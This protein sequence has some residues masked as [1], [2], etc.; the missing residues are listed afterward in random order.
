MD[1]PQWEKRKE[2]RILEKRVSERKE[3]P[4]GR[5]KTQLKGKK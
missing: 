4:Q 5:Y 3:N 1:L 2:D